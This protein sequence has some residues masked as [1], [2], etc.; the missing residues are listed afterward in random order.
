MVHSQGE[1]LVQRILTGL[2]FSFPRDCFPDASGVLLVLFELMP[3]EVAVWVRKTIGMLPAGTVKPGE[4][5]RLMNGISDKV[6]KGEIRKVRTLLQGT[7][8][9][10]IPEPSPAELGQDLIWTADFTN[11]YRRRN[12][13]PRDGLGR[14]EAARFRFSG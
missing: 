8:K 14:L 10:S 3:Q 5:E 4:A 6:Q 2:M 12:V 9:S 11:S 1:V 13:A 7:S